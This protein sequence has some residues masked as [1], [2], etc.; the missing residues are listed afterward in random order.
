MNTIKIHHLISTGFAKIK[1]SS[2]GSTETLSADGKKNSTQSLW[3]QFGGFV[4]FNF[5]IVIPLI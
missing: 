4:K 2:D 1:N 5:I 3:T